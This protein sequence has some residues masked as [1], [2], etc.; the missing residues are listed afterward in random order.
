MCSFH[1]S[2]GLVL[3]VGL[4]ARWEADRGVPLCVKRAEW[5]N[6][7]VLLRFFSGRLE[8][9]LMSPTAGSMWTC[10]SMAINMK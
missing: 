10:L 4:L 1:R 2:S 6:A 3:S 9:A 7:R 5:F 8:K